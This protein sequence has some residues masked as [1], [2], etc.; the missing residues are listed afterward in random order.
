MKLLALF[1]ITLTV[2]LSLF[3]KNTQVNNNLT[4]G[5]VI[6]A[7]EKE[8]LI[9]Y[10][11]SKE[12]FANLEQVIINSIVEYGQTVLAM[13]DQKLNYINT[14]S[15]DSLESPESVGD[16]GNALNKKNHTCFM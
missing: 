5:S 8:G 14:A 3:V 13:S 7:I 2:N 15:F 1:I 10:Q 6:E 9:I 4:A 11:E 16:S 12:Y